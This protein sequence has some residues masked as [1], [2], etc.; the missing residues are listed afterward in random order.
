MPTRTKTPAPTAAPV[1]TILPAPTLEIAHTGTPMSQ[2]EIKR[3]NQRQDYENLVNIAEEDESV[4]LVEGI[5]DDVVKVELPNYGVLVVAVGNACN[6]IYTAT[7]SDITGT[8]EGDT[9][10]S[11]TIPYAGTTIY[12]SPVRDITLEIQADCSWGI[13]LSD[14]SETSISQIAV[15]GDIVVGNGNAVIAFS[16]R[17]AQYITAEYEGNSNFTLITWGDKQQLAFMESGSFSGTVLAVEGLYLL[18]IQAM[19]NWRVIVD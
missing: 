11:S 13:A 4:V 5:G 8:R 16:G 14:L 2:S 17:E 9:L 15:K 18:E 7:V 1:N 6:G 10:F 19:G 12:Y 3:V